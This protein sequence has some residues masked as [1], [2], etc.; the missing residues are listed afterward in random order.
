MKL[1]EM[2]CENV[3]GGDWCYFAQT[4]SPERS[5]HQWCVI[6]WVTGHC[7]LEYNRCG[8]TEGLTGMEQRHVRELSGSFELKWDFQCGCSGKV[9]ATQ[10]GAVFDVVVGCADVCWHQRPGDLPL[11]SAFIYVC[12]GDWSRSIFVLFSRMRSL[13]STPPQVLL[14]PLLKMTLKTASSSVGAPTPSA[15]HLWRNA[16][17]LRASQTA[18]ARLRCTDNSP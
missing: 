17:P 8:S 10:S 12:T 4:C 5:L 1:Q 2:V 13:P 15:T 3:M 11:P 7:A 9:S 6:V 18:R 16:S 14:P